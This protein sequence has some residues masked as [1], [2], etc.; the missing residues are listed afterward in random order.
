[1]ATLAN[2]VMNY[3]MKNN[4]NGNYFDQLNSSKIIQVNNDLDG[5]LNG[6]DIDGNNNETKIELPRI[7]VVGSQSSGKSSV[8]NNIITMNI[9]PMGKEM[10]TRT[11]LSI[12][13]NNSTKNKIEFGKYMSN[14][15]VVEK[16]CS[17]GYPEPLEDEL[18]IIRNEIEKRTEQIAGK[19]KNISSEKITI[20]IY[21]PN[22]PNLTLVDLPGLTMVACTDKGQP[23]NIKE[24]IENLVIE[25]IKPKNTIILAVI[26]ARN[27]IEADMGLGLIKSVDKKFEKTLGVLT[28]VDLMNENTH[29]ANYLDPHNISADLRLKYGYF[30]VKNRSNTELKTLSI[31][32]GLEKEQEYFAK[33]P[34]YSKI[35][36]N[37]NRINTINLKNYLTQVLIKM[38]KKH[39]PTILRQIHNL[40][41]YVNEQLAEIGPAVSDLMKDTHSHMLISSFC[42]KMIEG[43]DKTIGKDVKD[44]FI[45]YRQNVKKINVFDSS[46]YPDEYIVN[47]IKNCEGN[48]MSFIL[49]PIGVIEYCLVNKKPIHKLI[50]PSIKCLLSVTEQLKHLVDIILKSPMFSRFPKFNIFIKKCVNVYIF[51]MY[52]DKTIEYI[53]HDV[54]KEETYI[55]TDEDIFINKLKSMA[56]DN[57]IQNI[58][59]LLQVYFSTV[60]K[61]VSNNIPKTI[62]HHMIKNIVDNIAPL[63]FDQFAKNKKNDLLD[64]SPK[65]AQKRQKLMTY[66]CKL[67]TAEKLL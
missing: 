26:P 51:E 58:R 36:D 25:Y 18:K 27:D 41:K 1:M 40:Q 65:M 33:H 13:L 23:S 8:L 56:K 2:T 64:E 12:Q 66:K 62:M 44:C 52:K 60:Q 48:H 6:L 22:V 63:L 5:I 61:S 34:I 24:Q 39:L 57:S 43:I 59:L 4:K 19:Q 30:L 38:V 53:E 35:G 55:W 67:D 54:L 32:Q 29:V 37:N 50:E 49:P 11:P 7:V 10:V 31:K 46:N 28:K 17:I 47:A 9:L 14:G 45:N 16:I 15:W 20:K 3:I 21:S 42:K